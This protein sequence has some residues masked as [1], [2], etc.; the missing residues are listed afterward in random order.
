MSFPQRRKDAKKKR[1]F[2][3]LQRACFPLRLCAFAGNF[4]SLTLRLRLN[5]IQWRLVLASGRVRAPSRHKWL[6]EDFAATNGTNP[7]RS[8]PFRN[9]SSPRPRH[10]RLG[11]NSFDSFAAA[12]IRFSNSK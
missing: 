10:K 9:T 3:D 1:Q 7:L 6:A 2:V 11:P 8:V 12:K 5:L 4:F